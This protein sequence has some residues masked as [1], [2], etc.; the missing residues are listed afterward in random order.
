MILQCEGVWYECPIIMNTADNMHK[1]RLKFDRGHSK[2]IKDDHDD[3]G[4]FNDVQM[5]RELIEVHK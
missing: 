1:V 4:G 2:L 5:A 3:R